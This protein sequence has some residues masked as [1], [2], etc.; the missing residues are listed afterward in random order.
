M[1]VQPINNKE[2]LAVSEPIVSMPPE[3][4]PDY[5]AMLQQQQQQHLQKIQQLQQQ[6]QEQQKLNQMQ[7][8]Q[9]QAAA[10]LTQPQE[11]LIPPP[12]SGV[13]LPQPLQQLI[14]GHAGQPQQSTQTAPQVSC[15]GQ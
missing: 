6:L 9:P 11:Q 3:S 10:P 2:P 13:Q 7:S 8:Q 14:Q 12:S 1:P 15:F 4:G 5:V